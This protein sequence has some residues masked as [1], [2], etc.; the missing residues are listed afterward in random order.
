MDRSRA[1][2]THRAVVDAWLAEASGHTSS[3][4]LCRMFHGG[5]ERIWGRAQTTL[6]SVTL[7]A[8]AERV[9]HDTIERYAFLAVV[10]PLPNGNG[11]ARDTVYE[12]LANI[13]RHEL[14]EGLRFGVIELLTVIGA[15]T[16][17]ILSHDLHEALTVATDKPSTHDV[18]PI[19]ARK[20]T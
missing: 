4:E 8:I 14:I 12:R 11:R 20:T 17:E 6:G 13:P 3:I 5:L 7:T 9:L 18:V 19:A 16:A 15:L 2:P 1:E 10:T